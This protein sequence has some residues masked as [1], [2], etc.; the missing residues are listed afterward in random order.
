M[1]WLV[2][3]HL[4]MSDVAQKRD[5][6]EPRTVRD[7][8]Q[9]VKSPTR[10]K[11]LT[12]LTVCDIRGVGPGVW[13]NWKAMLLRGLYGETLEF[14]TGGSEAASRPEREAA[15]REA[16]AAELADWDAGRGRGRARPALRALLARLRHPHPRHLRPA[17]PRSS[18]KTSRR[19]SS[20]STSPATPPRPASPCPTIRASS[21]AS[22]ERWR[23]PAPTSS[24]R[25]PTPPPTASP[26]RPSGSRTPSG[27]PYER[28]RLTRLR[29]AVTRTLRGEIVAREALKD[30]DRHQ[31]ARARLSRA[32]PAQLRQH[33]LGHLHHHRGRDPRPPRPALRP[34]PHADRQQHLDLL[35]RSSPPTASRR[36]TSSTSRTSSG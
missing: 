2:R 6:A 36:S 12:V 11:L 18:T 28:A 21:P 23:S 14:L 9:A 4:L 27:K 8:A 24:T 30:K 5:L 13:N 16:L 10:L 31:E 29:N 35:A 22:P 17:G 19:W 20:S 3:N 15:A 34:R 1:A 7:F 32:D 26:P 33:R 25:A